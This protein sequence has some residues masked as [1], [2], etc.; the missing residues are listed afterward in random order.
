MLNKVNCAGFLTGLFG[1]LND[2]DNRMEEKRTEI[3][4]SVTSENATKGAHCPQKVPLK[5]WDQ[6]I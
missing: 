3:S 2:V 6:L 4:T 5:V 1:C